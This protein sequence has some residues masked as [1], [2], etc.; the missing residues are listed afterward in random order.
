M[1]KAVLNCNFCKSTYQSVL[2]KNNPHLAVCN[3]CGLVFTNLQMTIKGMIHFY[4]EDYFISTNP[5][6]KGYENYFNDKENIIKTF[7]R[8]LN[9][10]HRY[11][12]NHGKL[13]DVGCAAGFF[14]NVASHRGWDNYGIDIS[15]ICSRYARENFNIKVE[16]NL[17][18][19]ANFPDAYFDL[20]TMWDYLEHSIT[21]CDDIIKA[22]KLLKSEG[23]L[24]IATP[25]ISSLPARIFK[26]NWIG[27][28]LEE[29][30]YYFSKSVLLK[31]LAE[32]GFKILRVSYIGK[33]VSLSMLADRL[34]FYNKYLHLV[35]AKALKRFK[36]SFYCN[37][38]DIMLIIARKK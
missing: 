19:N 13:L 8:R 14:L 1:K 27:I 4:N 31:F 15:R 9:I 20:I 37:P 26:A 12:K 16:N 17:F 34:I 29:H 30:F 38:L 2:Y 11:C 3:N 28:K 22:A 6:A 23:L 7:E 10:I 36:M 33:Y 18:V 25:D 32:K 35:L 21:P 24:V 5:M